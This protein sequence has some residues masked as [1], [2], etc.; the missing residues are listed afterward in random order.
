[1]WAE[2]VIDL[3][4]HSLRRSLLRS[5]VAFGGVPRQWLFD[6]PKTVVLERRGDAVRSSFL[7]LSAA[8]IAACLEKDGADR[9]SLLVRS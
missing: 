6:N 1:M 4:I 9:A 5:A 7:F 2:L 8:L 3:D